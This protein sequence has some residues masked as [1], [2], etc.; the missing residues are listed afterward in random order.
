MVNVYY[1]MDEI[2]EI[3]PD[4]PDNIP[5]KYQVTFQYISE[6]PSYGT[7]SGKVKE[8]VTRPKNADG[9]YNM[10]APGSSEGRSNVAGIGIISL[11]AGLMEIRT[12]AQQ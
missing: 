4:E 8:V 1:S 7:V 11:T 6:D 10:T 12:I 3:D 9:T 2:G 5:D